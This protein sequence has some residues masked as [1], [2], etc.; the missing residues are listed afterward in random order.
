MLKS[1]SFSC[2][3]PDFYLLLKKKKIW[4]NKARSCHFPSTWLSPMR[5]HRA[6]VGTCLCDFFPLTP[7]AFTFVFC[8]LRDSSPSF[9][10]ELLKFN[11]R[12]AFL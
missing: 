10:N 3:I 5:G 6:L 1:L 12:Y 2:K 7:L 4:Q 9:E 11:E 8:V